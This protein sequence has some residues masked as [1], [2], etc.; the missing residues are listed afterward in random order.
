MD[1][2][3]PIGSLQVLS[4]ALTPDIQ[5]VSKKLTRVVKSHQ[6]SPQWNILSRKCN[7]LLLLKIVDIKGLLKS[8]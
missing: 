7:L 1:G 8:L 6:N 3:V 5:K 4:L 2:E